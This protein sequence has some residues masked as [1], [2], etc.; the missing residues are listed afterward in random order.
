MKHINSKNINF[1]FSLI[2]FLCAFAGSVKSQDIIGGSIVMTE[3]NSI[4][5][6]RKLYLNIN[7]QIGINRNYVCY[8]DDTV[9]LYSQTPIG[10]NESLN[11]YI[12][13]IVFSGNGNYKV[14][15]VDS[16]R[17]SNIYNINNSGFSIFEIECSLLIAFPFINNN[18]PPEF[19][20]SIPN[21]FING[22]NCILF[23]DATDIDGD[24]LS[25]RLDSCMSVDYTILSGTSINPLSGELNF[26]NFTNG[27]YS[28][29]VVIEE[30]R[31]GT[32]MNEY[33]KDFAID[34]NVESINALS[35]LGTSEIIFPNPCH[36]EIYIVNDNIL[37]IEVFDIAGQKVN[38]VTASDKNNIIEIDLTELTQGIYFVSVMDKYNVLRNYKFAKL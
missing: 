36:D 16:F 19:I 18:H 17:I 27:I 14:N 1:S 28:F 6:Q 3:I 33:P 35:F 11:L 38:F 7:P 5:F 30:W 12:D 10:I 2:I 9:I 24:S 8:D 23:I 32:K 21:Y 13:T 4:S 26:S 29:L 34:I 20:K 37:K 31:S 22:S 15:F 25:Y